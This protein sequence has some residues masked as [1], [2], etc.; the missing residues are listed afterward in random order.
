MP[1]K[2]SRI[3]NE[4]SDVVYCDRRCLDNVRVNVK[5]QLGYVTTIKS[6]SSLKDMIWTSYIQVNIL[7]A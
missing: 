5:E 6:M 3:S 4:C 7:S 1:L 2:S